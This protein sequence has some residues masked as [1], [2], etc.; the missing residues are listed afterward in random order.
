MGLGTLKLYKFYENTRSD[1]IRVP[2]MDDPK[3]KKLAFVV[4]GTS[5]LSVDFIDYKTY[6]Y[7]KQ[8]YYRTHNKLIEPTIEHKRKVFIVLFENWIN[9]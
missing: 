6:D 4:I 3:N 8:V 5:N 9:K 2:I 7:W 1:Y